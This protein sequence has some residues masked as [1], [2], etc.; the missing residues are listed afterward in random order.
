MTRWNLYA[1]AFTKEFEKV[2]A[3][4]RNSDNSWERA[5]VTGGTQSSGWK[6]DAGGPTPG[7]H[8]SAG[9]ERFSFDDVT[10]ELR[11]LGSVGGG[12]VNPQSLATHPGLPVVYAAEYARDGRIVALGIRRDGS[13]ERQGALG[14]VGELAISVAVHPS[15]KMAYVAHFGD[16]TL[17]SFPLDGN[18]MLLGAEPVVRGSGAQESERFSRHHQVRATPSGNGVLVTDVARDELVMYGADADGVLDPEPKARV[19]FPARSGPRHLEFHPSGRWIYVVDE[20]ASVLHVLAADDFVPGKIHGTY[21]T[22]PPTYD[23]NNRPSELHLHPDGQ[24]LFV[25]NRGFDSV[26]IFSVTDSGEAEA[27]GYEPGRGG[28]LSALKVAPNGRYL[29]VGNGNPGNLAVFEID[30]NRS[31]HAVSAP[32]ELPAPRSLVFAEPLAGEEAEMSEEAP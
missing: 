16:G 26:T 29:M 13:L 11:H 18:G 2:F 17:T 32:V 25:G 5:W 15:G 14:S 23:G 3:D 1:G 21:S 19:E 4:L 27:I 30:A 22:V 20:R 8:F 12:I 24:T 6:P 9:I 7:G 10:G 28:N 31:L